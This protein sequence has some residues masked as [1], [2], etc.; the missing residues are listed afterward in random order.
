MLPVLSEELN[1]SVE[2]DIPAQGK[3]QTIFVLK[4]L[5]LIMYVIYME[6]KSRH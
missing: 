5:A 4:Y 3:E 2:Q 1:K 6:Y